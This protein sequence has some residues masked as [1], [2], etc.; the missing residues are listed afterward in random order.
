MTPAANTLGGEAISRPRMTSTARANA[1]TT[2]AGSFE[3]KLKNW[4]GLCVPAAAGFI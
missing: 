4:Q 1:L 2:T 3:D